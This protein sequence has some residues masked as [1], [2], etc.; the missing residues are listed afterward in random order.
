MNAVEIEAAVTELAL[1]PFDREELA[2]AY[3]MPK[4]LNWST[5]LINEFG[6][7]RFRLGTPASSWILVS[8]KV[9]HVLFINRY[10]YLG[11]I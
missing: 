7:G 9:F 5:M 4:R 8:A 6:S 1:R 3:V 10:V 2:F 11:K